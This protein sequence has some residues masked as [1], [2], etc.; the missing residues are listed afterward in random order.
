MKIETLMTAQRTEPVSR[1]E[2][3]ESRVLRATGQ[4]P[5]IDTGIE[6]LHQELLA[7]E[8]KGQKAQ[9]EYLRTLP[10]TDAATGR[11]PTAQALSTVA[12]QLMEHLK[13]EGLESSTLYQEIKGVNAIAFNNNL[14]VMSFAREVFKVM[15]DDAWEK[16]E[17]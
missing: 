7:L 5:G 3:L 2:P 13:E 16:I 6:A 15:D 12:L 4:S 11:Y 10:G 9:Y 1:V 17:W 14:F 8:G